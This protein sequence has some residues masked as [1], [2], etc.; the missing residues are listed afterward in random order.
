MADWTPESRCPDCGRNVR[1]LVPPS[2]LGELAAAMPELYHCP[3]C[4]VRVDRFGEAVECPKLL[5]EGED[6]N[7]QVA[8]DV[9]QWLLADELTDGMSEDSPG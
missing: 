2:G 8:P 3:K 4:I 1:R 6:G 5:V 7:L 9:C